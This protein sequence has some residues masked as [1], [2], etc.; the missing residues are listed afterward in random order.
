MAPFLKEPTR[1]SEFKDDSSLGNLEFATSPACRGFVVVL[2]D[3]L[4]LGEDTTQMH[5]H[6]HAKSLASKPIDAQGQHSHF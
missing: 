5:P 1:L 2:P 6:S 3:Y 4:G